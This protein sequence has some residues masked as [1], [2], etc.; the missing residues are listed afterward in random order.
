MP[1]G[2]ER[3]EMVMAEVERVGWRRCRGEK[4]EDGEAM[5]VGG[6]NGECRV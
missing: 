6:K 4:V 3:V 2:M 1:Q 5:G